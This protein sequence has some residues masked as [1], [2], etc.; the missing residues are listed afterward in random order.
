MAPWA[1]ILVLLFLLVHVAQGLKK[2][3]LLSVLSVAGLVCAMVAGHLGAVPAGRLLA[4]RA[5]LDPLTSTALGGA[6]VF[7]A[8]TLAFNL[9][10]LIVLHRRKRKARQAEGNRPAVSLASR[11]LGGV[12][13][14]TVGS[15]VVLVLLWTYDALRGALPA[16]GVPDISNSVSATATRDLVSAGARLALRRPL[17]EER[18]S[19]VA[20][21]VGAPGSFIQGVSALLEEPLVAALFRDPAFRAALLSGDAQRVAG[22]AAFRAMLMDPGVTG[23][24]GGMGLLPEP[25]EPAALADDLAE[26]LAEMG[27]RVDRVLEDPDVA[28]ALASLQADGV[29]N[30][31][32]WRALLTDAR[33]RLIA[34][35][36]LSLSGDVQDPPEEEGGEP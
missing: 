31:Q 3:F 24:L 17:G 15:A 22:N 2:G 29:F 25:Y 10:S 9:M 21:H 35:R 30:D 32:D 8:V 16:A 19:V 34:R 6:L 23:R 1:D 5:D 33:T 18:A 14:L 7:L 20:S 11:L 26:P 12:V 28:E 36:A 13:G 27:G 4:E